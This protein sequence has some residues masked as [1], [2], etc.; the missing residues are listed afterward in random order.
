[1]ASPATLL[2]LVA[3]GR[4]DQ[5]LTNNPQFTF[6]KHVYR[7][8]TPFAIES[9][10]IEFDG[11]VDFG[12]RITT[13][14]PRKGEL[15][16]SL[17]IEVELPP[18]PQ[19]E[20]TPT[21][22][23]VND[24]GH[25]LIED[26]RIE[27][28]E[29]EFDKHTGQWLHIWDELTTPAEKLDGYNEMVGHW[30]VYPPDPS[31]A[32]NPLHLSIPL[33]FWFCNNIGAALPLIALQA[34]PVRI[35]VYLRKFQELWWSTAV[36]AGPGLP[37]PAIEPVSPT[38]FQL[39]GDYIFLDTEERQR[40]ASASHEYLIDQVQHSPPQ[41]V[42]ANITSSNISL[43]FNHCCKE[44]LWVIREDRMR[45]AREW[46]NFSNALENN[47]GEPGIVSQ[48]P[49]CTALIRLD[50][51][52]RFHT[53]GARYFRITQPY[54]RHTVVPNDY[55]YLYSFSL[56]PEEEQPSGSINC[57]KFDDIVL[58]LTYD[59]NI[60]SYDRTVYVYA[61]NYNVVR[62]TGGLAGLAF[63]A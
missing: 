39:Y 17:F 19:T 53:R 30:A 62:I 38:R 32:A 20:G 44:F 47:G 11:T 52:D 1:M 63:L 61:T 55:I 60:V 33:R 51:Y 2:S 12:R 36:P 7:R 16:S 10:P 25:A 23:W 42:A 31:V 58:H 18:L 4:Q 22:Y 5:Y 57:S 27:I 8:Y 43:A 29:K 14:I 6:F 37:C 35:V 46:F 26:V 56:R 45:A 50:G 9:I 41:S 49:L 59:T 3:R 13:I 15:L 21:N 40:F 48:D 54:Q 28:G 24:I 34:H